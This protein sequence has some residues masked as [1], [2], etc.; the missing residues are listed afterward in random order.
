[1]GVVYYAN[2]LVW[3]EVGR[4]DWLRDTGWS[5]RAMEEDGLALPVIEAHCDYRLSAKYDDEIEIRTRARRLSPLRIQF[6]YEAVRRADGAAIASGHTVHATI[7]RQG[8]PV[9]LPERVKDLFA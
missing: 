4:T 6:D 1:M 2:Y 8:R 7:D 3:F 9:R 5:Y